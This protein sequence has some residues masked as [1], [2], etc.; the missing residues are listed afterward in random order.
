MSLDVG[1]MEEKKKNTGVEQLVGDDYA[2][3]TAAAERREQPQTRRQVATKV[4]TTRRKVKPL[5]SDGKIIH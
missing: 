2:A 3:S 4:E 5:A 1:R